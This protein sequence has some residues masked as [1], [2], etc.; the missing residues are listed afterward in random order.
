MKDKQPNWRSKH[1]NR[2]ATRQLFSGKLHDIR[3]LLLFLHFVIF[4]MNDE[5]RTNNI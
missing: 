5:N 2:A 3:F 4:I 1:G